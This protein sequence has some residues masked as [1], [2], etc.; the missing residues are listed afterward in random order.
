MRLAG[1]ELPWRFEGASGDVQVS[2]LTGIF[3][4]TCRQRLSEAHIEPDTG[5]VWAEELR[6]RNNDVVLES[7]DHIESL[8]PCPAQ[9]HWACLVRRRHGVRASALVFRSDAAGA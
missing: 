8:G 2:T 7:V 6:L 9:G 5:L 1:S 3:D 4:V